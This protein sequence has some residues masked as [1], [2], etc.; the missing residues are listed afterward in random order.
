VTCADIVK[1]N[2]TSCVSQA[3]DDKSQ[4]DKW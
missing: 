4:S 3:E 1:Q 2:I